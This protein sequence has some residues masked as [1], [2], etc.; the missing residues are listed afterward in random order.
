MFVLEFNQHH[1]VNIGNCPGGWD[2][3]AKY[4]RKKNITPVC[5]EKYESFGIPNYFN[6]LPGKSF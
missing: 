2:E 5:V 1:S 6:T 3:L 4:F